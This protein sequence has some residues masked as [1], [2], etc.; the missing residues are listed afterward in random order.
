MV[1]DNKIVFCFKP[2]YNWN[3]F[4]TFHKSSYIRFIPIFVLNL[5]ITGIPSI[6][7]NERIE[8]ANKNSVLNLIITGIP[9]ILL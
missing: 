6:Q 8:K 5:I 1:K 7:A 9:S 4:N 3:T 2:Y